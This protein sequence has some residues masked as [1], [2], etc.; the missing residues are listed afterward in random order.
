MRR[1]LVFWFLN[2]YLKEK[3]VS[4]I[5]MQLWSCRLLTSFPHFSGDIDFSNDLPNIITSVKKYP[6]RNKFSEYPH[7]LKFMP[8]KYLLISKN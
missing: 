3:V 8:G 4:V 1:R 5:C 6:V 7:C 2:D